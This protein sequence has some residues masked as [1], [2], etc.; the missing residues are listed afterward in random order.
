MSPIKGISRIARLPRLGKIR[1]GIRKEGDDGSSHPLPTDYFVC[2]D[3]VKKVFGEK[4][5]ELRIMFPTEDSEQWASQYLRLYSRSR[6]LI[7]RG[8][9]ETAVRLA[10]ATTGVT[11]S[12]RAGIQVGLQEITCNP[13]ECHY[14]QRGRCHRVM[15]LQFQLP[16]CPGF[17]VYQLDTFNSVKRI[18]SALTFIRK[19]C[20]RVSMIPL[21]L[22]LVKQEAQPGGPG[23]TEYVL[24]LTCPLSL[25]EIQRYARMPPGQALL[26]PPPDS[27]APDDLFSGEIRGAAEISETLSERDQEL[28]DLWVKAK[29]KILHFDIRDYQIA[30]YFSRYYNLEVGLKDFEPPVPPA[31]F[32]AEQL[33]SF[34]KDI[35]IHTQSA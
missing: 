32:T 23:K 22:Q 26:L 15:N 6:S 7:C 9:G 20:Q 16:D 8:D 13:N 19:A 10:D 29:S 33:A 34:I 25:A 30:R 28:I 11:G 17:G 4:P 24:S 3:E 31:R 12:G 2:P 18:D 1:L 21:S 27:E 14:Y 35:E 5:K